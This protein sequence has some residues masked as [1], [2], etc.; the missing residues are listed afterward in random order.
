M[1][2]A[3]LKKI[4]CN[5]LMQGLCL[6]PIFVGVTLQL[7]QK[8]RY[9]DDLAHL[10]YAS[11]AVNKNLA[12]DELA[13]IL[14]VSRINNAKLQVTGVLL[15]HDGSFFQVL[16]GERIIIERLYNKIL[17]DKRHTNSIKIVL[18][19][20]DE[21][22]FGEWT[23]GYPQLTQRELN[24]IVGVNDFFT[25]GNTFLQLEEG[26]TRKLLEGFKAQKWRSKL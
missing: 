3:Y 17:Q 20:I 14:N 19:S 9:M 5:D 10:V 26:R 8:G 16:E 13:E 25:G 1:S 2:R 12:G 21:R 23:M 22:S 24:N 11:A 18:E 7:L 6:I 15:F 4:F